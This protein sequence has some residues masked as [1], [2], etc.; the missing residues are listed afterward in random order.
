MSST[1]AFQR[2]VAEECWK[3]DLDTVVGEGAISLDQAC[4]GGDTGRRVQSLKCLKW[5]PVQTRKKG[6]RWFSNPPP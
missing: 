3:T 1:E 5:R 4:G 6:N 2:A